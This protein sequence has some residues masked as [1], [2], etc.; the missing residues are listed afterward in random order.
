MNTFLLAAVSLS[1]LFVS[2]TRSPHQL[3]LG[4]EARFATDD[5][6]VA[7]LM[8]D[9]PDAGEFVYIVMTDA[10][11]GAKAKVKVVSFRD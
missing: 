10:Q 6:E 9:A 4:N 2:A 1:A 11:T 5:A 8:E 7:R 3:V